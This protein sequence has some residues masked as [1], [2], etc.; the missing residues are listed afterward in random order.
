[1]QFAH[2]R[3]KV[4]SRLLIDLD[5]KAGVFLADLTHRFDELGKVAH[6]LRLDRHGDHGLRDVTYLLE[7]HHVGGV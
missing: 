4:L 6:V 1:M 2:S 3:K 7:G 5:A